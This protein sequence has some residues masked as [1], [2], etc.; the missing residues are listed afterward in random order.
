MIARHFDAVLQASN[1]AI[2]HVF[3]N[4]LRNVQLA[5]S[6]GGLMLLLLLLLWLLVLMLMITPHRLA[7]LII[8][9]GRVLFQNTAQAP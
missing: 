7:R 1:I 3:T 5:V 8:F 9:G 4:C 6:V 2:T